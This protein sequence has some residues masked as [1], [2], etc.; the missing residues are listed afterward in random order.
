MGGYLRGKRKKFNGKIYKS[1]TRE[2]N[3]SGAIAECKTQRNKGY[4]ARYTKAPGKAGK[5][6][7]YDVYRRKK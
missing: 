7:F 3:K 6:G 4:S 1:W 5:T 2:G